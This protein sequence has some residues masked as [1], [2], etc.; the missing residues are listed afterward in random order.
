M[1]KSGIARNIGGAVHQ[2]VI[3]SRDLQVDWDR[4]AYGKAA[5]EPGCESWLQ[6]QEGERL[7]VS[8]VR[9]IFLA[10]LKGGDF[11]TGRIV[12]CLHMGNA[13][14]EVRTKLLELKGGIDVGRS[15]LELGIASA[16]SEGFRATR[17]GE[18]QQ[19]TC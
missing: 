9:N 14:I 11:R 10:A 13:Y 1:V 2:L 4:N 19:N 5:T 8:V 18:E 15:N 7:V 17:K 6:A 16:R 12:D 3:D